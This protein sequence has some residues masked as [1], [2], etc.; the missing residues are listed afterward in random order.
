[1]IRKSLI[2][3]III[4]AAFNIYLRSSHPQFDAFQYQYQLNVIRAQKYVYDTKRT[5]STVMLGTSLSGQLPIPDSIYHLSFPG[6]NIADGIEVIKAA[7]ILPR[8]VFIE[9]NY[10]FRDPSES[11]TSLF[12]NEI[13]NQAKI[14]LPGM[15]DQNQP[16]NILLSKLKPEKKV[17]ERP[18]PDKD[19][20]AP[21]LYEKLLARQEVLYKQVDTALVNRGVDRLSA[22]VEKI[23]ASGAQVCFFEMPIALQLESSPQCMIVREKLQ[24]RFGHQAN[25]HFLPVPAN[26]QYQTT[27]GIHLNQAGLWDYG[28]YFM[29]ETAALL[30]KP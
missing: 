30:Q 3:F 20:V 15:R 19:A 2:V 5:S 4:F 8:T 22:F 27:D 1:M 6:L 26:H 16:A 11:F 13:N 25:V 10:F 14:W 17:T 7:N 28:V 12:T 18:S 21:A 29:Q 24:E 23:T 9:T